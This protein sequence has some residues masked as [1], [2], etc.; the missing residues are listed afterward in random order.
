MKP[1]DLTQSPYKIDLT[2]EKSELERRNQKP[3]DPCADT[4]TEE[5]KPEGKE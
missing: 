2:P 3:I 1:T 5:Q 4:D